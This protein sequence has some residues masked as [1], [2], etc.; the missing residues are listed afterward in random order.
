MTDNIAILRRIARR[1][2]LGIFLTRAVIPVVAGVVVFGVLYIL[3]QMLAPQYATYSWFILLAIPVGM[4]L[5]WRS[6]RI[7]KQFYTESDVV[8]LVDRLSH[9]DGLVVTA[10]ERPGVVSGKYAWSQIARNTDVRPLQLNPVWFSWRLM[11]AFA[12][13]GAA[14]FVPARKPAPPDAEIVMALTQP[15]ADKVDMSAELLPEPEREKLQKQ[16]EQ[17]QAE[18]HGISREKWDAIEDLE[19][20]VENALANSM[21]STYQ[22]SA[23]VN[24]LAALVSEQNKAPNINNPEL[25]AKIQ[26]M[27]AS[28]A[29]HLKKEAAPVSDELRNQL[30]KALANCKNGKCKPGDLESLKKKLEA[31]NQ[32][33]A[34]ANPDKRNTGKG[35]VDRGRADAPMEY[36]AER[37]LDEAQ[38]DPKQ[39]E[40]QY[41]EN[42]DLA[43]AGVTTLEPKPDP[44]RFNPG[45]VRQLENLHG[46]NVSRTE[47]S[48]SQKGVVSRYFE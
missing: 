28:L 44:G 10:Y 15:L 27:A 35:G 31:L 42:A 6:A 23:S 32:K 47:I 36:G 48:P 41:F 12:F 18:P 30:E 11:P 5:S 46:T 13:A 14:L 37:K 16:I 1:V 33:M 40:N 3:M 43:D 2:N 9:S 4:A 8:E 34:Q 22:L 24:Q 38:F 7:S 26:S 45:T 19:Q 20:R 29:D 21:A 17:V 39:L 25:Q